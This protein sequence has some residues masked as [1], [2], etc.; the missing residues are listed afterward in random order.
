MTEYNHKAR[1]IYMID[2][3]RFECQLAEMEAV[4]ALDKMIAYG[5]AKGVSEDKIRWMQIDRD[6]LWRLAESVAVEDE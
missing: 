1:K 6:Y 2:G 4:L 3:Q 5:R